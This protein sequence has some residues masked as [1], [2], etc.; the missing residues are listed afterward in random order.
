[1]NHLIIYKKLFLL[2]GLVILLAISCQKDTAVEEN[3]PPPPNPTATNLIA[4]SS[5]EDSSNQPSLKEWFINTPPPPFTPADTNGSTCIYST[6][7]PFGGGS[8]SVQ[9]TGPGQTPTI[10]LSTVVSNLNGIY[11]YQL[12]VWAKCIKK[13][14]GA[15]VCSASSIAI[16]RWINQ[17]AQWKCLELDSINT[18]KKYQLIDTLSVIPSDTI[19]IRLQPQSSGPGGDIYLFDNLVLN[20]TLKQ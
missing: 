5:F 7:V 13:F 9:L 2:I 14:T 12:E 15:P 19:L 8:W 1:M 17:T 20:A 10:S 11:V 16:G 4:N 18:W 3:P 6:D